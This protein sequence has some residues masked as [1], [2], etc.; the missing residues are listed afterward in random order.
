MAKV[1]A[2]PRQATHADVD[3]VCEHMRRIVGAV[4]VLMCPASDVVEVDYIKECLARKAY[5]NIVPHNGQVRALV[6]C[7]EYYPNEGWIAYSAES[8]F[9]HKDKFQYQGGSL[10]EYMIS[11]AIGW[12]SSNRLQRLTACVH[13]NNKASIRLLIN[14]GFSHQGICPTPSDKCP[15]VPNQYWIRPL[16]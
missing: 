11:D 3:N 15:F 12:A 1:K 16:I 9:L 5:L 6:I 4:D 10:M 7:T 8:P 2:C 13:G 14:A